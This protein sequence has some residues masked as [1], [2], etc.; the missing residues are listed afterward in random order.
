MEG[1]TNET[2][3][4]AARGVGSARAVMVIRE[5]G[6]SLF[7]ALVWWYA[8]GFLRAL[9]ALR[10]FVSALQGRIGFILAVR[11]VFVPMYQDYTP[12]GRAISIMFRLLFIIVDA[13]AMAIGTILALALFLIY[14]LLPPF[15]FANILHQLG[16]ITLL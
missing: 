3:A 2:F 6:R 16:I 14:V 4:Q 12:S 10:V 11:N 7:G 8:G 15:V 13:L 9:D 1:E 5:M